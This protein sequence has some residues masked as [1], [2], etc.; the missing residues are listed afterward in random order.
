MQNT[1]RIFV[2][3]EDLNQ[4]VSLCSQVRAFIFVSELGAVFVLWSHTKLH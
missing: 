2:N 1:L 3:R 4:A